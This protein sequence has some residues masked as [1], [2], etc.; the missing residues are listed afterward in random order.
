MSKVKSI[1]GVWHGAVAAA[2]IILM[3]LFP[4]QA[5][6][7]TIINPSFE[8]PDIAANLA[9]NGPITGWVNLSGTDWLAD[10]GV[11]NTLQNT[12]D[13]TPDPTDGEQFLMTGGDSGGA[14]QV[15][16]EPMLADTVYTLTV[17][18]GDRSNQPFPS[19]DLRLG[20]GTSFGANLLTATA[21]LAVTPTNVADSTTDGWETWVYTF[22]NGSGVPGESLR[23]ELLQTALTSGQ[24]LF[25]NVRLDAPTTGLD[26]TPPTLIGLS[27]ADGVTG[28]A[29]DAT[30][31]ATFSEPIA[32]GSGNI[33][34]RNL[35]DGTNTVV[36]VSDAGVTVA[37]AILAI[38]PGV[39]FDLAKDYAI[40][41]DATAIDDMS[42]NSFAGI[43]D[44]TTWNF[45]SATGFKVL[46]LGDSI[47]GGYVGPVRTA[48]IGIAD[49]HNGGA[50][51][52][53]NLLASLDSILNLG[54]VG[55]MGWDVIHF[56]GGLHDIAHRPDKATN[57]DPATSP[58]QY[59][60]NLTEI[61][62]RFKTETRAKLIW[63]T[64]TIV[65][66]DEPIRFVGDEV[67]YNAIAEPIMTGNG[68][69]INDLWTLTS[70][71]PPEYF[72]GPGNVH[73]N[74]SAY[75]LIS[76]QV[77]ASILAALNDAS[78]P[79]P[80]PMS[81]AVM[82]TALDATRVTMT[83]TTA[84][85]A[86]APVEYYIE[87]TDNADSREWG[88]A[89]TWV[90]TGLT[91]GVSYNY[92]VK[93]RDA[94]GFETGFSPTAS[95][96]PMADA[97]PPS[98]GVMSFASAPTALGSSAI[99][100]TATPASDVNGVEYFFD[101]MTPGGHDS[102]WQ[103]TVGYT[104]TGLVASTEYTYRVQARDRSVGQNTNGWS[105]PASATTTAP[106]L[107]PPDIASLSPGN[108]ATGVAVVASLV[109]TF[110]ESVRKGTGNI[111]VREFVGGAIVA[112]IDVASGGVT[113]GGAVVTINP[114]D[115][116]EYETGYY[117]EMAAGALEDLAG[118]PFA[119]ISGNTEWHFTTATNT[120][121]VIPVTNPS[122]EAQD[123]TTGFISG[124]P[125]GWSAHKDNPADAGPLLFDVNTHANLHD[126]VDKPLPDGSDNVVLLRDG[127]DLYQVLSTKVAPSTIYTLTVDAG[128]HAG[129]A[130]GAGE[131]WLGTGG[132]FGENR[133]IE[134]VVTSVIPVFGEGWQ[135][136]IANFTTGDTVPDAFLRVEIR[137]LNGG[138]TGTGDPQPFY[139][140]V[141]LTASAV[142]P[143]P[144]KPKG[145]LFLLR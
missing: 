53:G 39:D 17:E 8:L 54:G 35:T 66:P 61:V 103:D 112:T 29:V 27:P 133:L 62:N 139:D 75:A 25:D 18:I 3:A 138:E 105:V 31:A 92:R 86:S 52:T 137:T 83:A 102:G 77:T 88:T 110:D 97:T 132:T 121:T 73:M 72:V 21:A 117:V 85:D 123:A 1:E 63:A 23:V 104:D 55:P 5:V 41:I 42:T 84:S 124:S 129:K 12:T 76:P 20:T 51:P 58:A 99:T 56:N 135:T 11:G 15:T 111:L 106:D 143:T 47:S 34:I 68:V 145:T 38:D 119:G 82:P 60:T 107:T 14:Y 44:D 70:T 59:A 24:A 144:R 79:T 30:L 65:P 80:D 122:F 46:L 125:T 57:P 118:L 13:P 10:R 114:A 64:T 81:F 141:R 37:G 140:N 93:A 6:P 67:I 74:S 2:S 48:L 16:G 4:A 136:W 128:D 33:T 127:T 26:T 116:F 78:P 100:M 71:F 69:A 94:L 108:G 142:I 7:I 43:A 40:Q 131:I 126:D 28:V 9:A 22:T 120:G 95:A 19:I 130:F 98:P 115:N 45:T 113:I 32:L 96:T 36:A 134:D 109:A 87:N 49:V 90:N 89:A 50:N 101:S 91:A